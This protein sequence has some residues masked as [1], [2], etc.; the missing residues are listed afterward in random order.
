[1]CTSNLNFFENSDWQ[2]D[3][4]SQ[5]QIRAC[6]VLRESQTNK[7]PQRYKDLCGNK[8]NYI[9]NIEI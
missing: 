7:K 2:A 4:G 6:P 5:R 3:Y 9:Y 1:M 8:H